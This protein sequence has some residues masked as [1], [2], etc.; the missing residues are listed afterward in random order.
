MND[1]KK[2]INVSFFLKKNSP[3]KERVDRS[4]YGTIAFANTSTKLATGIK[5]EDPGDFWKKGMFIH[6]KFAEI[7]AELYSIKEKLLSF[8]S[9]HFRNAEEIK[10]AYL[11]QD[12]LNFPMT[13]KEALEYGYQEKVNSGDWRVTTSQNRA[14]ALV[15]FESF[16][17]KR[18]APNWGVVRNHPNQISRMIIKKFK[19][20]LVDPDNG[21]SRENSKISA[22]NTIGYLHTM[23][24]QYY[25]DH[26]DFED[27]LIPNPFKRMKHRI[28]TE[29]ESKK[30]ID[31]AIDWKWIDAIEGIS[32]KNPVDEKFRQISLLMA[33][34]GLSFVELGKPDALEIHQ[35]MK[36]LQLRS[37]RHKTG[38]DY[39]V[40]CN[41]RIID[42]VKKIDYLPWK[43]WHEDTLENAR[44]RGNCYAQLNNWLDKLSKDIKYNK[45]ITPHIFRHTF[46]MRMINYYRLP[47]SIVARM[48]GDKEDM[49]RKH[50]AKSTDDTIED[51]FES[52]M[53]KFEKMNNN[54]DNAIDCVK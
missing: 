16:R 17:F 20:W 14:S 5:V 29:E 27:E 11:G 10:N 49:V 38:K 42:I 26:I 33:Y 7:N 23:Y 45:S 48:L 25:Y 43:N 40:P 52:H 32:Y 34:T 51:Q 3:H 54:T 46:A 18:K 12:V 28:N 31:R 47:I 35:G 6:P 8:D 2:K 22:N 1:N 50:Y 37:Q 44:Y 30:A 4:V 24:E 15:K 21:E 36:G 41:S 13:M 9:K 19:E 39:M 53:L